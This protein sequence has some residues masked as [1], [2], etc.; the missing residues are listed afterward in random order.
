MFVG[1]ALAMFLDNT[2]PG[3]AHKLWRFN[4]GARGEHGAQGAL[5][6]QGARGA[7]A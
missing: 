5:G 6:T 7:Y 3:L 2:V 1:G 4:L